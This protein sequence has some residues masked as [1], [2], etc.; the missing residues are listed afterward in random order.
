MLEPEIGRKC[1][2]ILMGIGL[3]M[4]AAVLASSWAPSP[5]AR[6]VHES[7]KPAAAR[8]PAAPLSEPASSPSSV[9]GRRMPAEP[10]PA[11]PEPAPRD[12]SGSSENDRRVFQLEME[13]AKLRGRLDDMLTWILDNV[14]GTYP[15]PENQ[16]VYLRLEPV[17]EDL[18]VSADLAQLLRLSE[19]EAVRLD[20]A[21]M[22]TRSVLLDLEAESIQVETPDR[23]Q[24]RILIPPYPEEG[25]LVR[26]ALYEELARALGPARFDRFLQVAE[27]GLDRRFEYFGEA[28]RTLFFEA[29]RD[30]A[31]GDAQ[32]FVRDERVVP[33]RLDPLRQDIL[34]SERVVSELP[35]EYYPYW[36]WLPETVTGLF[37]SN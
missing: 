19:E 26:E 25:H 22:G 21:F 23:H 15:L 30:A 18:G 31:T 1:S 10:A 2:A 37:R 3:V 20:A 35:E 34:A 33:N 27:E 16:M 29:M 6:P 9:S 13:N 24:A 4:G 36:N 32:L 11:A 17:D 28:D 12:A 14:R 8:R 5:D 7:G